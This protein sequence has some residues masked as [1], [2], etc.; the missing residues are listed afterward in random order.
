M[1]WMILVAVLTLMLGL[2]VGFVKKFIPALLIS[3]IRVVAVISLIVMFWDFV[4]LPAIQLLQAFT[5]NIWILALSIGYLTGE[6]V[7]SL[8]S[9]FVM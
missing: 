1:V 4:G 9:D 5:K 2:G 3:I 6:A 8:I 7:G